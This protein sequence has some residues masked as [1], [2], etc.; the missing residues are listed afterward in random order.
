[1]SIEPAIAVA[2]DIALF[3]L[4]EGRLCVLLVQRADP[5]RHWALPGGPVRDGE[6]L[7]AAAARE[8]GE[9]TG[10]DGWTGGEWH[11]EQL[12]SYG[13]PG[14]DPRRRTV[15]VAYVAIVP[16]LADPVSGGHTADARYWPLDEL[17]A[18]RPLAF[19]HD[20]ILADALERVRSKLE[21]SPLAA[22]FCPE[23]FTLGQLRR[24]YEAVWGRA[25]DPANFQRKA[26]G[27]RGFVV[28]TG[29]IAP[30]GP[31]G[32]RPARLYRRGDAGRLHPPMLR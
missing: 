3:T 16:D 30:P 22:A 19:D 8:L 7:D 31:E 9:E 4:R 6:D 21:Y 12:R 18:I 23:P 13:A 27:T 14:R 10:L 5:P 32:G 15:A 2:V 26:L 11:L 20:A 28:P 25:L 29:A 17:P 1:M 24:V